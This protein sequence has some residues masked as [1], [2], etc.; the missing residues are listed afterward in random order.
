MSR[1]IS[2][3]LPVYNA[4]KYLRQCVDSVAQLGDRLDW[5][6]LL[7]D[8]GSTDSSPSMCDEFSSRDDRIRVFHIENKGVS[9]AR[10]FGMDAAGKDYVTFIDADDWVDPDAFVQAFDAFMEFDVEL[11]FTPFF[12]VVSA[13]CENVSLE[14]GDARV[15][16]LPEK[17]SLLKK[18]LAAGDRFM[19]GVWKNFY[20]RAL[21]EG[22]FFDTELK[23][24]EDVFFLVQAMYK[25]NRVAI[26]NQPFYYYRINPDSANFNRQVNSI[27]NRRLVLGKMLEW[28]SQNQL[29]LSFARMRRLCP[30]YARMF[31]RAAAESRRGIP[32]VKS[33]WKI[34]R[35]IPVEESRQWKRRFWGKSFAPYSFLCR[36]GFSFL[37]FLYLCLRFF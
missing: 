26:V 20:S 31:A 17:D 37:G 7:I 6:L 21:L 29:D 27:D 16:T 34:H 19:G 14:C 13:K 18:R 33:L 3:I 2:I 5:E 11:G 9:N 10:N 4:E 30:L 12:R 15:L 22:L 23:Y 32:R 36:Y 24:Q 1:S 8:D 35:E 28:A 25:A